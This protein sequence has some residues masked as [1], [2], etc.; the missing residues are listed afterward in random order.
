MIKIYSDEGVSPVVGVMLML[1]VTIIIAAVVSGFAGGMIDSQDKA[2]QATIKGSFSISEGL[3]IRHTG[4]DPLPMHDLNI[5]IWDGP[6]FG[7]DIEI[8]SK[9]VVDKSLLKTGSFSGEYI[10][11]SVSGTY[12]VTSFRAGDSI[13]ISSDECTPDML[14][15]DLVPAGYDPDDGSYY[16]ISSAS[17]NDK[18]LWSMCLINPNNIGNEFYVSIGDNSG[19]TIGKASVVVT[20]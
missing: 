8:I 4:G 19:N 9:Q 18:L 11:N 16:D 20:A 1:V 14:Q 7:Q 3:I 12:N 17:E 6:T 10:F 2:S 13:Y 15:P 5:I